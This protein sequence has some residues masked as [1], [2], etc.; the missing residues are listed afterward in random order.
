MALL[1]GC[2]SELLE[3][4]PHGSRCALHHSHGG[5]NSRL[6]PRLGGDGSLPAALRLAEDLAWL[7][8]WQR[9]QTLEYYLQE[10]ASRTVLPNLPE[11]SRRKIEIISN[12]TTSVVLSFV[13]TRSGSLC[14]PLFLTHEP[15][16]QSDRLRRRARQSP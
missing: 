5:A 9:M 3:H 2:L 16:L 12:S 15:R 1:S 6:P 10:V 7:G 8:R 4:N 14:T 13:E 11:E